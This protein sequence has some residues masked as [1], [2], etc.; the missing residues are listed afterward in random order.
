MRKPIGVA[1]LALIGSPADRRSVTPTLA[2]TTITWSDTPGGIVF[3]LTGQ[4]TLWDSVTNYQM[5][6]TS[7]ALTGSLESALG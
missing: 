1:A 5:P 3:G 6:C 7:G 4:I 2:A